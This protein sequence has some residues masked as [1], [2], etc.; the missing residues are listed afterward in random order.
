MTQ[1]LLGFL[2]FFALATLLRVPIGYILGA[3][4]FVGIGLLRGWEAA[5]FSGATEIFEAS[6]YTLSIVPLF[7]LMGNFVTQGGLSR[8]LYQ[9]AYAFL[10]H[11]RGG[12]ITST[13]AASAGFG[14]VCGS[15]AATVATMARVAMPQMQRLGYSEPLAAASIAAGGTL[16]ILIP[17][18]ALMVIYGIMTETSIGA[19]FAAGLLPGLLAAL[20]YMVAGAWSV[21]RNPAAGPS[22]PR[23]DWPGRWRALRDI[24]AVLLLFLLV[25]GGLYSGFFTSTEAAG[26]GAAGGFVIAL[27]R[28]QLTLT[29]LKDILIDSAVTTGMVFAIVVG[30][31]IF[32]NFITFTGMPD[33]LGEWIRALGAD[34]TTLLIVVS[35]IYIALGCV[36]ESMSML[37]LTIPVFVPVMTSLGVDPVWFGILLVCV[38]EVGLITPPVGM[39]VFVIRAMVPSVGV[40]GIWRALAPFIVADVVRLAI[41]IGAPSFVLFLP[42]VLGLMQH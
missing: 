31:M 12:L 37:L 41:L 1:A 9:A 30:A 8:D 20:A 36:M 3:V 5:V 13:I 2:A 25:I 14:A 26:V 32:A 29:L 21:W 28:R 19:L 40:G 18:S 7:V 22:G 23:T 11:R 16:G 42:R 39:N 24:W 33:A 38:V 4:G 35:L 27:A 6:G 17:P 34:T 10:G 15:S